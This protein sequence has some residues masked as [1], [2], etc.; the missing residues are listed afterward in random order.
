VRVRRARLIAGAVRRVFGELP[1]A[2][3]VG[4]HVQRAAATES[5]ALSVR[6]R[7]PHA[8]RSMRHAPLRP[9]RR[10]Q[11]AGRNEQRRRCDHAGER[12]RLRT[13]VRTRLL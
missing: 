3:L 11:P 9:S 4:R 2:Q 10:V 5:H 13:R 12:A 6:C 1:G 7:V 8:A